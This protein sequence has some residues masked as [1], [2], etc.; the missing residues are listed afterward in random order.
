ME[1][2]SKMKKSAMYESKFFDE[3]E[4][5]LAAKWKKKSD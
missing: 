4:K 5:F 3:I 2:R 1:E